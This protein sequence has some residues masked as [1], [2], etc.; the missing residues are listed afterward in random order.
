MKTDDRSLSTI[1]GKSTYKV[2]TDMLGA[3]VPEGRTHRL[4]PLIAG[5]LQYALKVAQEKYGDEPEED[6]VAYTIIHAGYGDN[7]DDVM[8]ELSDLLVQLFQDAGAQY[9]RR[10]SKG[11]EYSIIESVLD[12]YLRWYNMPWEDLL[13]SGWEN[14]LAHLLTFAANVVKQFP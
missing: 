5:M 14:R 6:T 3:L 10:S 2:W 7:P 1:V 13:R 4:A 9:Q 11:D 8:E 12:E